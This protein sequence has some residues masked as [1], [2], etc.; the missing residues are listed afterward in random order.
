[1]S[2]TWLSVQKG[3]MGVNKNYLPSLI[4]KIHDVCCL[5]NAIVSY[6]LNL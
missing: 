1:M 5:D 6:A 2:Q 3:E 4:T